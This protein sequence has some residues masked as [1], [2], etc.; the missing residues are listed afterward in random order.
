MA[1]AQPD[2]KP[3]RTKIA[4][5]TPPTTQ[6]VAS[7]KVRLSDL[8][9]TAGTIRPG[10]TIE[11]HQVRAVLKAGRARHVRAEFTYLG[12]TTTQKPLASGEMRVQFG[13][14]LRAQNTC[15][16]LYVMWRIEP[17]EAIVVS[18]K[19]NPGQRIHAECGA[20]NY[21]NVKADISQAPPAMGIGIP[22]SLEAELT[23]D[24]LVV[25]A[26]ERLVWSGRIPPSGLE[27]D[28]PAGLR[29]DNGRFSFNYWVVSPE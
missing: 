13:L 28:G 10:P 12:H 20:S 21:T 26:D 9:V 19:R 16:V 17:K 4:A 3:E 2:A 22:H 5:S 11:H 29:T 1:D 24:R 7:V 23:G 14:K 15:N 8:N 18:V 27:F 25:H 6:A